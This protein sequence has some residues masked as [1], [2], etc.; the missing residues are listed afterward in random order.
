MEMT[1]RIFHEETPLFSGVVLVVIGILQTVE[2]IG[3]VFFSFGLDDVLQSVNVAFIGVFPIYTQQY[4]IGNSVC[5]SVNCSAVK[6]IAV[7]YSA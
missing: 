3:L 2:D 6:L 5:Y 7:Q 1:T 4:T